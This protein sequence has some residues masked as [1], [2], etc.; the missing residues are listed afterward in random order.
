MFRF[1][2]FSIYRVILYQ[3]KSVR[4]NLPIAPDFILRKSELYDF[5]VGSD[6]T[7]SCGFDVFLN[8]ASQIRF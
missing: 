6:I 7:I 8:F 1:S 4:D 3:W 5:C 2:G